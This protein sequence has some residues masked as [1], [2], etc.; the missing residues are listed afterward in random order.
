[1]LSVSS[2]RN[3]HELRW[4]VHCSFV[5]LY[6]LIT[7]PRLFYL[8]RRGEQQMGRLASVSY[9][10]KE[11]RRSIRAFARADLVT[12]RKGCQS[13]LGFNEAIDKGIELYGQPGACLPEDVQDGVTP[14]MTIAC[15]SPGT[16]P[17]DAHRIL[18]SVDLLLTEPQRA[19]SLL[20]AA[21]LRSI[22]SNPICL[23]N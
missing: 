14:I 8:P 2:E 9:V 11:V 23:S 18:I 16:L 1:M 22:I 13:I 6:G 4:Q 20:N 3:R 19:L 12:C 21:P 10:W 5:F 17:S 15:Q 7:C